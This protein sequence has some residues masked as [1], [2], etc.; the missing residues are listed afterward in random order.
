M[1]HFHHLLPPFSLGAFCEG[2]VVCLNCD[3]IGRR[4]VDLELP[5]GVHKC[6]G[7]LHKRRGPQREHYIE[8]G[9][10]KAHKDVHSSMHPPSQ[11]SHENTDSNWGI[12]I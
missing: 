7:D 10:G 2:I 12:M 11:Y 1:T 5:R 8:A 4:W 6:G 9:K 3:D